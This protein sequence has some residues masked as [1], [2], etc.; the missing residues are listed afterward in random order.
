[1][2]QNFKKKCE[3]LKKNRT[4]QTFNLPWSIN[5]HTESQPLLCSM[6]PCN[7]IS[8]RSILLNTSY[9]LETRKML[10]FLPFFALNSYIFGSINQ[11]LNPSLPC[12]IWNLV[13]HYQ[14]DPYINTQVI[15]LKLEKGC[16]GPFLVLIPKLLEP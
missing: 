9:C 10:V 16:F 3:P 14:S 1:M 6:E 8:E 4:P 12:V 2:F 13:V 5:P 15:I 11:K 7:T